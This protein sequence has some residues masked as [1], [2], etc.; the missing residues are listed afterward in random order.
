MSWKKTI[1]SEK[2]SSWKDTIQNESE[3]TSELESTLRG[4]AQGASLGFADEITGGI[5][6]LKD[7]ALT[8]KELSDLES[9]YEQRRNESRSAYKDAEEE[10]PIAYGAGQVG[11][12]I[13]TAFVPGLNVAKGASLMGRLGIAAAQ[14]GLTGLGTSEA[15]NI[16]DLALDTAKGAGMNAAFQGIGEKVLSPIASKVANKAGQISSK[17]TQGDTVS[18]YLLKKFGNS[19]ANVSDDVTNRY[20][21]NPDAVNK[22]LGIGE[23]AEDLLQS[24]DKSNSLVSQMYKKA[25]ELSGE[26]VQTLDKFKGLRKKDLVQGIDDLIE[27]LS[28]DGVLIGSSRKKASNILTGLQEDLSQFGDEISE[29][30]IKKVIQ[31]IDDDVDWERVDKSI[32]DK[33]KRDLRTFVDHKLKSQNPAYKNAMLKTEEAS[34]GIATV[35][36]AFEN[37]QNPESFDKFIKSVK[38]LQNKS[39]YSDV[40]KAL[41]A[42]KTHTGV[43]LRE[44]ILNSQAKSEFLKD[45]TNGSRKTLLGKSIGAA[46]DF[47]PGKSGEALGATLGAASD[48]FAGRVFK[49]ML[50]GKIGSEKFFAQ[51]GTKLGKYAEVLKTAASKGNQSLATTHYLLSQQDP[52]Y[53]K[54]IEELDKEE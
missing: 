21:T 28:V 53:R 51:H 50:D 8:D 5:E 40:N 23:L 33:V 35:K 27:D 32:S 14:G 34:E 38:N 18:D 19:F 20:I 36:K 3:R 24:T 25:S 13:A 11:G 7:I 22:S 1:Q 48:K 54:K 4:A 47:L 39:E 17:I 6:A 43:D 37:R 16:S 52:E 49:S 15:D 31:S 44:Q 45:T 46:A 42:I 2:K 41:E 30:S 26:A 12:S 9:L 29:T 10:N